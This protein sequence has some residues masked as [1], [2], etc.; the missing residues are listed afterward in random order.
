MGKQLQV[1]LELGLLMAGNKK[2]ASGVIKVIMI[3]AALAAVIFAVTEIF[4]GPLLIL[5][6]YSRPVPQ[7]VYDEDNDIKIVLDKRNITVWHDKEV[8][9]VLPAQVRAQSFLYEDADHDGRKDLI[10]LC[11]RRGRYGKHKPTWVKRDEI[12]W[13]QHIFLYEVS[14]DTI[15]PKW[16]ASDIGVKARGMSFEDKALLLTDTDGV[17]SKWIWRSW[18]FEKM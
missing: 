4:F 17:V 3:T 9:W 5:P 10:V 14:T 8:V 6:G 15:R 13:S 18:G 12:K 1:F 7:T 16:M 11:W 2:F